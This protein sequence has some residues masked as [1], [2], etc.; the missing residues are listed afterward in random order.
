MKNPSLRCFRKFPLPAAVAAFLFFGSPSAL[1]AGGTYR[2]ALIDGKIH[3]GLDPAWQ[4]GREFE[5]VFDGNAD[6]YYDYAYSSEAFAGFDLGVAERPTQIRFTPRARFESRMIGGKFQGSNKSPHRGYVTLHEVTATP[7]RE[8]ETVHLGVSEAYRYYRYLAPAGGYGNIAEFAISSEPAA[9]DSGTRV[10]APEGFRTATVNGVQVFGL[11]PAWAE[12]RSFEKAVDG[13]ANSFYDYAYGGRESFVGFDFGSAH[14]LSSLTFTPRKGYEYRMKGGRFEVSNESPHSGYE[15]V[16]TIE[17]TPSS[18]GATISLNLAEAY[19][20][21]RYVAPTNSYG[22]IA[23]FYVA[24]EP[25]AEDSTSEP[26]PVEATEPEP[27]IRYP[28]GYREAVVGSRLVFGLDPAWRSGREFENAFDGDAST[29]Y[30]FKYGDRD[31]FVGVD[32]G[33][34]IVPTEI[35]FDARTWYTRRMVGGTFQGSNKSSVSGYETLHEVSKDPGSSEQVVKLEGTTAYR[36][37]RFLAPAGSHGNIAEFSVAG[38][39]PVTGESGTGGSDAVAM[40]EVDEPGVSLSFSIDRAGSTSAGVY[41]AEGRLVRTLL[42]GEHLEAGEHRLTWDGLDRDGNPMPLGDYALRTL[43]A[44]GGRAE[45]VTVIGQNPDSSA[46]DFWLGTDG[47]VTAAA[48]DNSG[49]YLVAQNSETAPTLLKQSFD[50]SV[51]HWTKEHLGITTGEWQ[52]GVALAAGGDSRLYMLQQNGYLQVIDGATGHRITTWDVLPGHIERQNFIYFHRLGNIAKADIAARGDTVVVSYHD[53]NQVVWLDATTGERVANVWVDAPLGVTVDSNGR[54]YAISRGTVVRAERNGSLTTVIGRGLSNPLRLDYDS[55]GNSLI[56]ADGNLGAQ[57]K[58]FSL[59]GQLLATYGKAGGRE[60]GHYVNTDFYDITDL[61]ADGQGGFI[62]AEPRTPP[63]R[64]AHFDA[65]GK[66][67]NEW[68]GGQDYYAYVKPDPRDPTRAWLF[69]GE[70]LVLVALDLEGG[71]WSVLETWAPADLADGLVHPLH[72]FQGQWE[73]VY[74]GG[75]RYL[76]SNGSPQV[77][78][79]TDGDLRAVSITS[80]H[81]PQLDR[82]VE[83][84]GHRPSWARSFYWFDTDGDGRPQSAEI[85]FSGS[86]DSVPLST[87][88]NEDFS[89]I[90]FERTSET[91]E[92]TRTEPQWGP[93]GPYYPPSDWENQVVSVASVPTGM[94]AETRGTGAYQDKAG[95]Y[96]A[97]YNLAPERHGVFWPTPWASISRFVKTDANGDLLWSVGRHAYNGGLA[98]SHDTTYVPTPDGQLHVPARV[99]GETENAVILADRVET[100]GMIWTKDGLYAGTLFDR[101]A[102]DGLPESVY[103]WYVTEDGEDAITTSD[104]GSGGSFIQYPDGTTLWFTQGR[105]SV[106]VYEITGFEDWTRQEVAF[107]LSEA[108][109]VA[110]AE[111]TGLMAEYFD[112]TGGVTP[113]ATQVE[114]QIWHGLPDG[115]GKLDEVVDGPHGAVYDWSGGNNPIGAPSNY[116]V[117]WTGEIEAPV[118]DD[119][120]FSAYAR[121]GVRL[122]IDGKQVLYSWNEVTPRSESDPVRL[123]AGERYRIQLDFT[124]TQANPAVSLNWESTVLDRMRVPARYLYPTDASTILKQ[125]RDAFEHVWASTFDLQSGDMADWLTDVYGVYGQ[126]QWGFGKTGSY[127]GYTS[128][129]F[130]DEGATRI[131]VAASGWPSREGDSYPVIVSFRLGAPDGPAITDVS[132]TQDLQVHELSVPEITGVH[133]V[134]AVNLTTDAWHYMDFR[135]FVFE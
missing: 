7:P 116:S 54:V 74:Q 119:Y 82:A 123:V 88:V 8:G 17:A 48:V 28:D 52:G 25:V 59:N 57:V 67:L 79:H 128:V 18:S 44:E 71:D 61:T 39:V 105:N 13:D 40:P 101:R 6:T 75:Q 90:G 42:R 97:F 21:V 16:H 98:G 81:G 84:A 115:A 87:H 126:R 3:F 96:Y 69:T 122:W 14:N 32:K 103:S 77:L 85:Q 73:V 134:Y 130:G 108:P 92:I 76:V 51:R 104:N 37:Y 15:V 58:R 111:G 99:I 11:D 30:D 2:E 4:A 9:P 70:G 80:K 65:N 20:Y 106:P 95:N 36:Y 64:V 35:R 91:V 113:D 49:M 100:P 19:R 33:E 86:L 10:S 27:T 127:L 60:F 109:D 43:Q 63:R 68:F 112:G 78:R 41:D 89:L 107:Q 1:T 38:Y 121:G 83:L 55:A 102:D 23:A 131:R 114:S 56:V 133:D 72:G 124:T 45:F 129:D 34:A 53:E 46:H 12:G 22:N 118:T 47:G 125:R 93:Y 62:V 117:R 66:V 5:D 50:G 31:S 110:R 120:T 26:G 135:W 94:W 132:L 24:T 29:Y